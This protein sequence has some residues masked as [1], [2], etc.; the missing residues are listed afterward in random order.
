MTAQADVATAMAAMDIDYTTL[1]V[2]DL[3]EGHLFGLIYRRF[4][5]YADYRPPNWEA[6]AQRLHSPI[7][8]EEAR[9][10]IETD[11]STR[12]LFLHELC[13]YDFG[14]EEEDE[15]LAE[16]RRPHSTLTELTV[17]K[18][19]IE[20]Y[21]EALRLPDAGGYN[22]LHV[23]CRRENHWGDCSISPTPW[24][25]VTAD[26]FKVVLY[27]YPEAASLVASSDC[28]T[29]LNCLVG[30]QA[31]FNQES[32]ERAVQTLL[33]IYPQALQIPDI[34][35]RYPLHTLHGSGSFELLLKGFPKAAEIPCTSQNLGCRTPLLLQLH[36]GLYKNARLLL[37][38]CPWSVGIE[39]RGGLLID[40]Y[41]QL[42]A[43]GDALDYLCV[44]YSVALGVSW[45]HD[46][47][48]YDRDTDEDCYYRGYI[49]ANI[50]LLDES[51]H[52]QDQALSASPSF[53]MLLTILRI[54]YASQDQF[55]PL[56][57]AVQGRLCRP[58]NLVVMRDLLR[59]YGE[60]AREKDN[61]GNL[62]LHLFLESCTIERDRA[63]ERG[64]A[65][66]AIEYQF[67]VTLCLCW[68]LEA[69]PQAA[70]Q[71]NGEGRLPLHLAIENRS[72]FHDTAVA[73]LLD[74]APRALLTRDIKSRL[75]PFANAAVGATANLDVTFNLLQR[76]PTVL[77][78]LEV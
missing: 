31:W 61:D 78:R 75:Y 66:D 2:A 52:S 73:P 51:E 1:K 47:S 60:Q 65:K 54:M 43:V 69:N 19:T 21:P 44:D 17:L 37:K 58:W 56:H 15:R 42:Y 50:N 27:A 30:V 33:E 13:D 70:N 18:Q 3:P 24:R 14:A 64:Y 25:R 20:V 72:L 10:W 63:I 22:P 68:L 8:R 29:A 76:D 39:D 48:I 7:G 62:P 46:T 77:L 23:V 57:A 5:D 55:L 4:E 32:K 41:F 12:R 34:G 35:G 9:Q 6:V 71:T 26:V 40:M 11:Y 53:D 74:L 45:L 59:R 36:Y 38:T 28:R 49:D 67:A 16:Q